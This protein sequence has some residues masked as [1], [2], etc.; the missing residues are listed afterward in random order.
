MPVEVKLWSFWH[1]DKKIF[2]SRF[3][4][5]WIKYSSNFCLVRNDEDGKNSLT[6]FKTTK[7]KML[8]IEI[9]RF[10]RNVDVDKYLWEQSKNKN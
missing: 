10:Q 7:F 2:S 5:R 3:G 8:I 4:G 6:I 1:R 9:S